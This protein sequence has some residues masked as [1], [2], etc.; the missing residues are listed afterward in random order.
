MILL[1]TETI[2]SNQMITNMITEMRTGEI[3]TYTI[4]LEECGR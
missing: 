4:K 3:I 1:T 2:S